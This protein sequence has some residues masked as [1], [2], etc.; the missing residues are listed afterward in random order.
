MRLLLVSPQFPPTNAADAQRLRMLLPH[1]AA[2]G[3]QAEVLAVEPSNLATSLDPWQAEGLPPDVP[4]HRVRGLPLALAR[5]PGLGGVPARTLGALDRAGSRLLR[6]GGFDGVYFSTTAFGLFRLGPRWRRRF[7]V[8]F[9]LDYQDPWVNDF[10]RLHPAIRP[11]GGRLKQ[12]VSDRLNRLHEPRVLRHVSGITAVSADYGRQIRGRY[13]WLRPLPEL[14]LPFPGEPDDFARL[15]DPSPWPLPFD[16]HDGL[17]HWVSIGR[18]GPDLATALEGL[19]HAIADHADPQLRR[20][21]RLHFLGTSYAAAG[22][23]IPTVRPLAERH[24][25][26]DC[27]HEQTDRM[28][29]SQTL[30]CLRAAD[31][32]L[33]IGSSDP[34][35]T[36]SKIYPYLLA[37][38]PLL[39]VMHR[40]SS[41]VD[42]LQRCGGGR[43]VTFDDQGPSELLAAAIAEHWLRDGAHG[44]VAPLDAEAFAPST[45]R[46]QAVELVAFLRRCLRP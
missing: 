23:G 18:G 4:V 3:C 34:G 17:L 31:A 43:V 35:Y 19:F 16:P 27:V 33:V 26:G 10:Y 38:R 24:G 39:A 6:R 40:C 41:V 25:L 15:S 12:A 46:A 44:R 29:L 1:L 20:R 37:R 13:P 32:L 2:A 42:L 36:A 7:G 9:V 28:P 11:P 21:L 45:A 5:L 30:R 22:R 8:P 14:V